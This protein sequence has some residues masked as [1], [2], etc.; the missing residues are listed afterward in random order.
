LRHQSPQPSVIGRILHQHPLAYCPIDWQFHHFTADGARHEADAI[1]AEALVSQNKTDLG[2][3]TG[4][5]D[6][7]RRL[8]D[9][10]IGTQLVKRRIWIGDEFRRLPVDVGRGESILRLLV[11]SS[12]S[13]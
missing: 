13:L 10:S 3:A 6:A 4:E 7:E 11:Q 2:M 9:R 8:L 5:V 12:F 1:P